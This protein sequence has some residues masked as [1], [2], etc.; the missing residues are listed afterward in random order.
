M[1]A[2]SLSE[3]LGLTRP[4]PWIALHHVMLALTLASLMVV[5]ERSRY[6]FAADLV[7]HALLSY[8]GL[9]AR[10]GDAGVPPPSPAADAVSPDLRA[11]LPHFVVPGPRFESYMARNL[12]FLREFDAD[13]LA[14]ILAAQPRVLA[15]SN[16]DI[17]PGG[18]IFDDPDEQDAQ[19]RVDRL[20]D[21]ALAGGTRVIL[22]VP[23][24][25]RPSPLT[26]LRFRWMAQRCERGV[27]FAMPDP[28]LRRGGV[29]D[30]GAMLYR[31]RYPSL[32]VVAAAVVSAQARGEATPPLRARL[33]CEL[34]K[35]HDGDAEAFMDELFAR[36]DPD[37]RASET[38]ETLRREIGFVNQEFFRAYPSARVS[39]FELVDLPDGRMRPKPPEIAR[40]DVVFWSSNLASGME[41]TAAGEAPGYFRDALVYFSERRPLTRASHLVA[42]LSDVAL[43]IALG[44]LFGYL[45]RRYAIAAAILARIPLQPAPRKLAAW[46]RARGWLVVAIG[47]LPLI[48]WIAL[49]A[50]GYGAVRG[51]W[52]NP[53]PIVVGMFIDG[54]LSS[55]QRA[56]DRHPHSLREYVARHLDVVFV[57]M[58]LILFALYFLFAPH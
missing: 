11:V 1:E 26:T 53:L 29:I 45:W 21:D 18:R 48:L 12:Q 36:T 3:R 7:S 32:G 8:T 57:Q 24:P 44:Y 30:D 2:Q 43:G 34:A 17:E 55:R 33:L 19:R 14:G 5:V 40:D 31:Y 13:V 58:P 37:R 28:D 10:R 46:L 16:L 9:N 20:L 25:G 6:F 23:F 22:S 35:R 47:V 49:S 39:P 27:L 52:L 54:L 42:F 56:G 4:S 50:A 41:R 15:V 38:S 51:V